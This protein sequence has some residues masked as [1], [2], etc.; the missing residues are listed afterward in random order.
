MEGFLEHHPKQVYYVLFWIGQNLQPIDDMTH[1]PR[2]LF[3]NLSL[4]KF[5]EGKMKDIK[6]LHFTKQILKKMRKAN[7]QS[8]SW[9]TFGIKFVQ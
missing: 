1:A 9:I 8:G 7:N 2:M 3:N 4:N 6:K 5:L